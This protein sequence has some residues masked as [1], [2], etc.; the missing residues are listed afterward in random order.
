MTNDEIVKIQQELSRILNSLKEEGYITGSV[1]FDEETKKVT[2]QVNPLFKP[3]FI[4]V[5]FTIEK[6][7]MKEQK[8]NDI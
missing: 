6:E 3:D 5:N 7:N 2:V 1:Q 4:D 8:K